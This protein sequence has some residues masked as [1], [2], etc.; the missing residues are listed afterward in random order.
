MND[1]S[2]LVKQLATKNPTVYNWLTAKGLDLHNLQKNTASLATAATFILSLPQG[3]TLPP[4]EDP[5]PEIIEIDRDQ[6]VKPRTD[7]ER[8]QAVWAQ[9]GQLIRESAAKYDVDPQLIF[10]TIMIESGGNPRAVRYEPRLNDASYGLGQLLYSTARGI[11][12]RGAPAGLYD[13][14]TN[15]DL[16]ARY[17]RRNLDHYGHLT[18]QELTTAYNTGSPKKKPWPGHLA[19]F[20]KWYNRVDTLEVDLT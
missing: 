4:P 18:A 13:P 1:L 14:A 20:N 16:I 15:I 7:L 3:A 2:K 11:G 9:Y 17:H 5:I 10:A 12:Y 19:K 8:G 6:S